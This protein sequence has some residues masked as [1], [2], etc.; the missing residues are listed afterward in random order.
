MSSIHQNITT[1]SGIEHEHGGK[2][3]NIMLTP[4]ARQWLTGVTH[5]THAEF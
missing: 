5:R 4:S 2:L 1:T 3:N